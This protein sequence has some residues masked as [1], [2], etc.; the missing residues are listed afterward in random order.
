VYT[1]V[2]YNGWAWHWQIYNLKTKDEPSQAVPLDKRGGTIW[3]T[4][5]IG[6]ELFD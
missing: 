5:G 6:N 2:I 4:Y 3:P 1:Y